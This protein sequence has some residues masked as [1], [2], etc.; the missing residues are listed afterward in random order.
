MAE[1][2]T[3]V[4]ALEALRWYTD[5]RE[6][7]YRGLNRKLRSSD[8][9]ALDEP[10]QKKVE[11][12]DRLLKEGP[13]LAEPGLTL[14]RG[15]ASMSYVFYVVEQRAPEVTDLAYMSC[16]LQR[17]IGNFYARRHAI[18]PEDLEDSLLLRIHVPVGTPVIC[19]VCA[20][21]ASELG[22]E[23]VLLPRG[24]VLR[25]ER[26]EPRNTS[27]GSIHYA[28]ARLELAPLET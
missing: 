27:E 19:A 12:M 24:S 13:R 14:W 28:E 8:G 2:G 11:A 4:D 3:F 15:M 25:I 20:P 10:L 6:A 1:A 17:S 21:G 7:N 18:M 22:E 26:V 16:S 9:A 5:A 23:E